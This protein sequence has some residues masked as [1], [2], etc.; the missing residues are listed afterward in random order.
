MPIAENTPP[1][2]GARWDNGNAYSDDGAGQPLS[3]M[4]SLY[5]APAMTNLKLDSNNLLGAGWSASGGPVTTF[6]QVGLTGAPN[7]ASYLEDNDAGANSSR[8][9]VGISIS[10]NVGEPIT[11]VFYIKK[12]TDQTRFPGLAL[13]KT[14]SN[15]EIYG[16]NTETGHI[17][18]GTTQGAPWAVYETE[19][20]L[21]GGWWKVYISAVKDST[22]IVAYAAVFAAIYDTED[23]TTAVA[24]TQG[25]V[26]VGN[27]EVYDNKTLAHVRGAAPIITAGVAVTNA[28]IN[29]AYDIANH[30]NAQGAY[31]LE[32]LGQND[33]GLYYLSYRLFDNSKDSIA[34]NNV[35][36]YRSNANNQNADLSPVDTSAGV[37]RKIANIYDISDGSHQVVMNGNDS[38]L[39]TNYAGFFTEGLRPLVANVNYVMLGRNYQRYDLAYTEAKAKIDDLMS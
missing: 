32:G 19:V 5:A 12:D 4:P 31:Y 20:E 21:V 23:S 14:A 17:W 1:W 2:H 11:A 13:G 28:Q 35:N 6:D 39:Y 22:D 38:G 10:G 29:I 25:S 33:N 16:F 24:A 9:E 7:T 36:R 15:N 30:D 27:C 34:V 37:F 8:G 3:V 26:I 18:L